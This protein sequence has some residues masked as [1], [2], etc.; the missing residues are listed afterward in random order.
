MFGLSLLGKMFGSE[1]ALTKGIEVVSNGLDAL[2][3]TEE[4]KATDAKVER[5]A[6]RKMMIQWMEATQGQNLTRRFIAFVVTC[7][8]VFMHIVSM[9]L[10]VTAVALE[11]QLMV[12]LLVA[13]SKIVQ[14]YA[15][16]VTGAMMLILSFYFAAPHMGMIV[17]GA[18]QRFSKQPNTGKK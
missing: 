7:L 8:W 9:C 17:K 6:A 13:T 11:D 16:N 3:Y 5:A 2:V 1:K 18:M 15:S 10:S 4:E 14:D 12:D